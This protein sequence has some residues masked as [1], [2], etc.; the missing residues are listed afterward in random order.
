MMFFYAILFV[1]TS[2]FLKMVGMWTSVPTLQSQES[3]I[4]HVVFTHPGAAAFLFIDALILLAAGTLISVQAYQVIIHL[5]IFY[6]S[7]SYNIIS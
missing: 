4:H 3:W 1:I 5:F 7:E 6:F 2:L